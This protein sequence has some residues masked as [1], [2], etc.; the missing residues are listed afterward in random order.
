[1]SFLLKSKIQST[2]YVISVTLQILVKVIPTNGG[3]S[4]RIQWPLVHRIDSTE[5]FSA[6]QYLSFLFSYDGEGS[7]CHALNERG[8]LCSIYKSKFEN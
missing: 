2:F 1:M 3:H 6:C 7:L 5:E 8:K 4:M